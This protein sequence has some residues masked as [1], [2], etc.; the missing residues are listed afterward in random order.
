V[1][2]PSVGN[3]RVAVQSINWGEYGYSQG[4][5]VGVRV[6]QGPVEL[7]TDF[8]VPADHT[9]NLRVTYDVTGAP[10]QIFRGRTSNLTSPN[11]D[12]ISV[13]YCPDAAG[14]IRHVYGLDGQ[15]A[16]C[17]VGANFSQ[18]FI[19]DAAGRL[20]R[21]DDEYGQRTL[22]YYPLPEAHVWEV[23]VDLTDPLTNA[24]YKWTLRYNGVGEILY[25]LDE[26][27]TEHAY[28][29]DTLGRLTTVVTA[30]Q[31]EASYTFTYNDANLLTQV[32]DGAGRGTAYN[33]NE[34]NLVISQLDIRTAQAFSYAYTPTGRLNT[35]IAPQGE[36][37]TYRYEDPNDP[38]RLTSVIDPSG[39]ERRFNWNDENN[40]LIYTD[41]LN[42]TSSYLFDGTGMLWR[43]N[44]ALP[45]PTN[46]TPY[47]VIEL[48][49]DS[50]AN[51]TG[52]L[53][54]TNDGEQNAARRLTLTPDN[55]N[56]FVVTEPRITGW[57]QAL[58]Y[59]TQGLQTQVGDL[60]FD[61][62][63]LYRLQRLQP[64]DDPETAWSL[65]W[66]TGATSVIVDQP[67]GDAQTLTF[68]FLGRLIQ[69]QVAGVETRFGYTPD[70][71]NAI[72]TLTVSHPVLGERQ[73]VV[74]PGDS[75][76]NLPPSVILKAFG[77]EVTYNYDLAGR[78]TEIFAR[79]CSQPAIANIAD[80]SDGIWESRSRLEY[81][82][83]GLLT[84]AIDADG[85]RET[86]SY[87]NAGE[88]VTYQA[89]NGRSFNYRYDGAGR[90]VSVTNVT[91]GKLLLAYDTADNLTGICR[92]RSDASDVY[93]DCLG[94]GT[95]VLGMA[96]DALGRLREK[97]FP[98]VGGN[99][100]RTTVP[101]RYAPNGLLAG[102]DAVSLSYTALGLIETLDLGG[103]TAYTFGYSDLNQLAEVGDLAFGYDDQG[104]TNRVTVG[105]QE[106]TYSRDLAGNLTITD[107]TGRT[108][109]YT[110]NDRG[111][112]QQVDADGQ[113]LFVGYPGAQ[114]D[115]ELI[116]P[117]GTA[118]SQ[119]GDV[120][121]FV[122]DV[123][124]FG[125][126]SLTIYNQPD[127]LGFFRTQSREL[128]DSGIDYNIVA[129]YDNDDRPVTLRVTDRQGLQVLY[130]LAL[131]YDGFG[132]RNIETRQFNDGVQVILRHDYGD[133]PEPD[134]PKRTQLQ[135]TQI[136]IVR[137][138]V[139]A[140]MGVWGLV[141]G[142]GALVL[143]GV[144]HNRYPHWPLWALI[145]Q[146]SQ[147]VSAVLAV[148]LTALMLGTVVQLRAQQLDDIYNLRYSYDAAGNVARIEIEGLGDC[149]RFAYDG[150]NRLTN[151]TYSNPL[152]SA[153]VEVSA[154]YRYD[155]F[156]RVV[157]LGATQVV[158]QGGT[159]QIHS[160][161]AGGANYTFVT[162]ANQPPL[163]VLDGSGAAITLVSDGR[164]RPLQVLD[165]EGATQAPLLFDSFGRRLSLESPAPD[166]SPCQLSGNP[167]IH[168]AL[169]VQS[170]M[171]GRVWDSATGLYFSAD[172]RAYS[173][174]LGR[175]LQRD[176]LNTDV[177]G[178]VYDFP[179]HGVELPLPLDTPSYSEGLYVL[180][181]AEAQ[182]A[183]NER[184]S[185]TAV[186]NIYASVSLDPRAEITQDLDEASAQYEETLQQLLVFPEWLATR[187]NLTAP[188]LDPQTGYVVVYSDR[189]VA[190]GGLRGDSPN[191]VPLRV[192]NWSALLDQPQWNTAAIVTQLGATQTANANRLF[193]PYAR[194]S[195]VVAPPS[196][197]DGF[198][199]P[200]VP[201]ALDYSAEAVFNSLP[202][203]LETPHRAAALLDVV[204]AVNQLPETPLTSHI[205][206]ALAQALPQAP[207]L[208]PESLE[209]WR[210]TYFT[211]NSFGIE[212]A[213][214]EVLPP[215]P[216]TPLYRIGTNP[217]WLF[218]V[219]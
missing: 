205:E 194:G 218:V 62:D 44:D 172:G 4:R 211:N 95:E 124:Y 13:A 105:R 50:A 160:L 116:F 52:W 208:P 153:S 173:A 32:Q 141:I 89:V 41:P 88:L 185:A 193:Q 204:E 70:T 43:I 18:Q 31:P 7:F 51:F 163:M 110:V 138:L 81:D 102:Y 139:A 16:S 207:T 12:V 24:T 123:L 39:S 126:S 158:Y 36:T 144:I 210:A 155:A 131:T 121:G 58:G 142:L 14:T 66:T 178:N 147:R 179:A 174:E 176:P 195:W 199:L 10:T 46:A 8:D 146:R 151:A 61:Y 72:T 5:P 197:L 168:P 37:T 45:L 97:A 154:D 169:Q 159:R 90:L 47:R 152:N 170:L 28:T 63:P 82:A 60:V 54:T 103:G 120:R 33:Y 30:Q 94:S 69:R 42:R 29:Y 214:Q 104:A 65:N 77:Q 181:D 127:A 79:V 177:L 111:Y 9:P 184:L 17:E 96:Y 209:A 188:T 150:L 162:N 148:A 180:R 100:G 22:A 201:V 215:L 122:R 114:N 35:V 86:F 192:P 91:G 23:I 92:T 171:D 107:S 183:I 57:S 80:C 157:T 125:S 112:V 73:Y 213:I 68:D 1:L 161:Q 206:T 149:A 133:V 140:G 106:L 164:E 175:F 74:S 135:A 219:E 212:G 190:Q 15:A 117:D 25:W 216:E 130:T 87:N 21:A 143:V 166:I 38:T 20:L 137:P 48:R 53:M 67:F 19:Y 71:A 26:Y 40:E 186:R 189:T 84:Q 6:V 109:Q 182:L 129:G 187:Y 59:S 55:G 34:R 2:E 11:G 113:P 156:N 99:G 56:G 27:G 108:I 115:L 134:T 136:T 78:L 203:T 167:P 83:G 64:L 101:Y 217:T 196:V 75:R 200:S 85:H 76:R 165:A 119:F 98:N 198:S 191:M 145:G 202:R 93:E 132:R 118:A 128:L 49:H 3:R